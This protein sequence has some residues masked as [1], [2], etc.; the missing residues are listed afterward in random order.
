MRLRPTTYH[1]SYISEYGGL[2]LRFQVRQ[3]ALGLSWKHHTTAGYGSYVVIR[4][5]LGFWALVWSFDWQ[6]RKY[7]E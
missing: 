6:E 2:V 7:H 1:I 5:Y 4:L 3:F